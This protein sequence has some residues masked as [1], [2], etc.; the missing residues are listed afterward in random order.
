MNVAQRHRPMNQPSQWTDSLNLTTIMV[1]AWRT[2]CATASRCPDPWLV[3]S[4]PSCPL[5]VAWGLGTLAAA[6]VLACIFFLSIHPLSSLYNFSSFFTFSFRLP[7]DFSF[8]LLFLFSAS[9]ST[10]NRYYFWT[11]IFLPHF[12]PYS[13]IRAPSPALCPWPTSRILGRQIDPATLQKPHSGSLQST[14]TKLRRRFQLFALTP[15]TSR[16]SDQQPSKEQQQK[17]KK[18]KR[19]IK[20]EKTSFVISP[21]SAWLNRDGSFL[22]HQWSR[23]RPPRRC[24]TLK[25][26]YP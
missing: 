23:V 4:P 2:T 18:K 19:R 10:R 6:T 24:A 15:P 13:T 11:L 14:F 5:S 16:R 3:F 22:S 26:I 1:V 9:S 17:K 12:S 8:F 7:R 21:I 25:G 20:R